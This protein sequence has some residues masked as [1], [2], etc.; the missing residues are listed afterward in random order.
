MRVIGAGFGRTGTMSL[1]AALE[2]LGFAPC[3]HM[4]DVL[5][6]P[7]R[8]YQ[9]LDIAEGRSDDW[10]AVFEGYGACVDWPASAYWRELA[11]HYP[12]AKVVLSVRDP[13]RWYDSMQ[14]TIFKQAKRVDSGAGRLAAKVM[15]RLSGDME[16][17][18][19]MTS[20]IVGQGVF[21]GETADRAYLTKVFNDH[22]EA[23]KQAIPAERLLVF[24]VKEGWEPL[25]RFL[26]VPVPGEPFPRVNDSA[27]FNRLVRKTMFRFLTHRS[28]APRP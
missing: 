27:D 6:E 20:T 1:K 26:D 2:G 8:I 17:Y 5:S 23:V 16:A 4:A 3:Y 21:A 9:W 22:V 13:D 10:D 19:R 15:F 7:R 18:T 14:A 24:N 12:Q 28:S 11:A 25:C